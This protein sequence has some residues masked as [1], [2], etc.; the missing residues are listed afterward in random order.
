MNKIS[1]IISATVLLL[2][3]GAGAQV[4]QFEQIPGDPVEYSRILVPREPGSYP[5]TFSMNV[6]QRSINSMSD[7]A[8]ELKELLTNGSEQELLFEGELIKTWDFSKDEVE[9]AIQLAFRLSSISDRA[10]LARLYSQ[11]HPVLPKEDQEAFYAGLQGAAIQGITTGLGENVPGGV[12][13]ALNAAKYSHK[14]VNVV[15]G[16]KTFSESFLNFETVLDAASAAAT[17]GQSAFPVVSEAAGAVLAPVSFVYMFTD[18]M[19]T[20]LHYARNVAPKIAAAK[21]AAE[22][23]NKFY[24]NVNACLRGRGEFEEDNVWM[25]YVK[26]RTSTPFSF[27]NETCSQTWSVEAKLNKLFDQ[28]DTRD[29]Y[30]EIWTRTMGGRYFGWVECD[31]TMDMSNYDRNFIP[32]TASYN[33]EDT[34]GKT[35]D[36]NRGAEGTGNPFRENAIFWYVYAQK[37]KGAEFTFKNGKG[38]RA[39]LHYSLPVLMTVENRDQY[40]TKANVGYQVLEG[41]TSIDGVD[42][43][44]PEFSNVK[45]S[46]DQS[47]ELKLGGTVV[48]Y[49]Y[50]KVNGEE[51]IE[52]NQDHEPVKSSALTVPLPYCDNGWIEIDFQQSLAN[53]DANHIKN[54]SYR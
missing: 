20:D 16:K 43:P 49:S 44:A 4:M 11:L 41:N 42:C 13:V 14:I 45:V 46:L 5:A 1:I 34:I 54:K 40:S 27:R 8:A 15:E 38:T 53:G 6:R 2:P 7:M 52:L 10:H 21:V 12:N 33:L 51:H 36:N 28:E 25:V 32:K 22:M 19:Y 24:K 26:G 9:D 29:N 23:I 3:I 39:S 30:N 18:A 37:T 48:E 35:F 50:E 47:W 17:V 31:V